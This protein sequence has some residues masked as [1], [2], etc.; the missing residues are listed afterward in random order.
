MKEITNIIIATLASIGLAF[1][2]VRL[3]YPNLPI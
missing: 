3:L 2:I 1:V